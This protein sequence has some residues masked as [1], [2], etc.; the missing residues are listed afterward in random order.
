MKW[1]PMGQGTGGFS[2]SILLFCLASLLLCYRII[3]LAFWC[4]QHKL[5]A[6]LQIVEALSLAEF[7]ISTLIKV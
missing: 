6:F 4:W 3:T 1:Y 5:L 7:S 2:A